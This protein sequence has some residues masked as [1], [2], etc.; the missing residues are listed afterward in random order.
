MSAP[1]SAAN[2]A[3]Y[4][5]S[6]S[7]SWLTFETRSTLHGVHGKA[8]DLSGSV[9]AAWGRGGN[10]AA[11]PAP[12]IHLEFPVEQLRSGN[13]VQDRE[14]WKVID[15]KRFPRIAADLRWL[16]Q[17]PSLGR[18]AAGGDI[19]MSGRSRGYE[20]ECAISGDGDF[21]TIEGDLNVDIREFGLTPPKL[22]IIKVDPIVKVHLHFVARK[23]A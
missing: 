9:E 3:R 2:A 19:T 22:L 10:I 20:G 18:Y 5:V 8:S 13:S 16:Q 7:E 1:A 6:S 11:E 17:G 12:K 4:S 21:I 14:M 15:S 23:S